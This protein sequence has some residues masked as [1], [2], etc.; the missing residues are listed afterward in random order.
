MSKESLIDLLK[1]AHW[2]LTHQGASDSIPPHWPAATPNLC[3]RIEKAI[4]AQPAPVAESL[5]EEMEA[6]T[7]AGRFIIEY[8]KGNEANPSLNRYMIK[9]LSNGEYIAEAWS[10]YAATRIV[11]AMGADRYNNR[12]N[13]GNDYTDG[14]QPA[15]RVETVAKA[16]HKLAIDC[17]DMTWTWPNW[18]EYAKVAIAAMV[19]ASNRKDGV[20]KSDGINGLDRRPDTSPE[21]LLIE[22][23]EKIGDYSVVNG[24]L[25]GTKMLR[26]L[27]EAGYV[28]VRQ[29]EAVHFSPVS[30]SLNEKP[31]WISISV[32]LPEDTRDV[33]LKGED[34][35]G[36][37]ESL[38]RV[39]WQHYKGRTHNKGRWM[40]I[41]AYGKPDR[42]RY[43]DEVTHWRYVCR[44]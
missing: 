43:S 10:Y 29:H 30:K 7:V 5:V 36:E 13:L 28:I 39:W 40:E 3:D 18:V 31:E 19:E 41:N 12:S 21:N 26:L 22:S 25:D 16:L 4:A 44:K 34:E 24:E 14:E 20:L 27:D 6:N 1:E 17:G 8:K 37:W 15:D 2:H 9:D 35:L 33:F 38:R 42:Y 11:D 23:L 32:S